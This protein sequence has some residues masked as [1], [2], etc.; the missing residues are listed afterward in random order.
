M[1]LSLRLRRCTADLAYD[2]LAPNNQAW[3]D[4]EQ[5][6]TCFNM[7]RCHG[8][9]L[10]ARST[11]SCTSEKIHHV[12]ERLSLVATNGQMPTRVRFNAARTTKYIASAVWIRLR[13][14]RAK[15]ELQLAP[16]DANDLG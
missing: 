11:C 14:R 12:V 8:A 9:G 4:D 1:V 5:G 16:H 15:V 10:F 2:A 6:V 13:S 7:K 3:Y